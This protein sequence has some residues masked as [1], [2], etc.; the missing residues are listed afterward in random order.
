MTDLR[1]LLIIL[2]AGLATYI[3]RISGYILITR[4]KEL[5]PRLET[6][7]NAVPAAVLT[8]L[9]APAFFDGGW[10]VKVAMAVALVVGLR[11]PG[12]AL[13]G[14]GWGAAM[15]LRHLPFS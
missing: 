13:I 4:L 1:F 11:Y 8:T 12:I 3:T 10:D 14:A 6:A 15:L 7:L 9:T 2:A 5:P